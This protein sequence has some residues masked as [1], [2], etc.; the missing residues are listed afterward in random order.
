MSKREVLEYDFCCNIQKKKFSW[1]TTALNGKKCDVGNA[2]EKHAHRR[3]QVMII[4]KGETY[5]FFG[6]AILA[7]G[8]KVE[9]GFHTCFINS[10]IEAERQMCVFV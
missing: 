6:N 8:F 4:L 9:S 10:G 3:K 1:K 7:F 2:S 5:F